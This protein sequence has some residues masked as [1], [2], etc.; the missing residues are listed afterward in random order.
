MS[1]LVGSGKLLHYINRQSCCCHWIHLNVPLE[2]LLRDVLH[3]VFLPRAGRP[4]CHLPDGASPDGASLPVAHRSSQQMEMV[5]THL[6]SQEQQR[7]SFRYP[8]SVVWW[9]W[10]VVSRLVEKHCRKTNLS[11]PDLEELPMVQYWPCLCHSLS[12]VWVALKRVWKSPSPPLHHP[13]HTLKM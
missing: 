5:S 13:R 11:F 2:M 9:T 8:K 6:H 3:E 10:A 7:K 1:S 4:T 12:N